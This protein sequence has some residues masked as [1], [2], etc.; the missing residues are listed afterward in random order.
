MIIIG[1]IGF[2]YRGGGHNGISNCLHVYGNCLS[3]EPGTQ[4]GNF[5]YLTE[6]ANKCNTFD[7]EEDFYLNPDCSN[8]VLRGQILPLYQDR[9]LYIASGIKIEDQTRINAFEFLR[10]L[11][12]LHHDKLIATENA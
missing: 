2:S 4:D 5:I 11:D 3:Y 12:A 10:L 8:F 6:N 7:D 9:E 1:A